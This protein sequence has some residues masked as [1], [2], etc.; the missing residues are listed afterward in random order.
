[1]CE[2]LKEHAEHRA[3]EGSRVAAAAAVPGAYQREPPRVVCALTDLSATSLGGVD[4]ED[5]PS[6][7]ASTTPMITSRRAVPA[8]TN[9]RTPSPA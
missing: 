5:N 6:T 8:Q 7:K 1:M 3:E 4:R 9:A 2:R